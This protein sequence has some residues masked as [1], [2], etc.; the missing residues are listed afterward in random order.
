ML[1]LPRKG[2]PIRPSDGRSHSL[3]CRSP[4]GVGGHAQAYGFGPE[5]LSSRQ[6]P[7][8]S[9]EPSAAPVMLRHFMLVVLPG[10]PRA[11]Q[12]VVAGLNA[13]Q[14]RRVPK[15]QTGPSENPTLFHARHS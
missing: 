1:P 2:G 3:A 15:S 5:A 13:S 9:L 6:N 12:S 4:S 8:G 7:A 11:G 10:A 14:R